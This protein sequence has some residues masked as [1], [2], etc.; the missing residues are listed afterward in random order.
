M[1]LFSIDIERFYRELEEKSLQL[2]GIFCLQYPIYCIHANITDETPDPL[3]NLDNLIV[4]FLISKPDLSAFQIASLIGT[5]KHLVEYRIAKLVQD[6][7]LQKKG[8]DFILSELGTEVF[9]EKTQIRQHKQSY[10]F[11]LDGITLKPLSKI[12]YSYYRTKLISEND[13]YYHTNKKGETKLI[14]PFGP[15]LVHTPP[16]NDEITQNI[17]EVGNEERG[18]FSI[19]HGLVSIDDTSFTKMS[20][21][22]LVAVS[23]KMDRIVK[24]LIDGH[25]IY[26]LSDELSY[27]E[28][29]KQNIKCFENILKDKITQLEFKISIPNIR[30]DSEDTPRPILTSNWA[31]VQKHNESENK[32]Y[33]FSSEDL[34]KV[35]DQIFQIKH[36]VPESL[37]NE[38]SII[39]IAIDK[40]TLFSSTDRQKL[41]ADLIRERDYKFGFENNNVFLLYL[42][43]KTDDDFVKEVIQFKKTLIDSDGEDINLNWFE[44]SQ[45]KYSLN[46]RRLLIAAG[47]YWLLEKLDIEKYMTEPN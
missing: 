21:H 44:S 12:Y 15:D 27:Y 41:V 11:Y 5:S 1:S 22:L 10:D 43:Y 35:V 8:K 13:S 14:Q 2:R 30:L 45:P 17:F 28:T 23:S 31:E 18:S 33:S 4:D 34:L 24:E 9:S 3:D 36:V 39:E 20:F 25:A 42:Y 16:D 7:L 6:K 26:S 19:P 40:N 46:Y 47:E 29:L 32:C 38:D 37:I